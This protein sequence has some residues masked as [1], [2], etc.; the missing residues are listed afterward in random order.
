MNLWNRLAASLLSGF[1][2]F[3]VAL[4]VACGGLTLYSEHLNGDVQ[5][6]GP[7]AM[8]G[9]LALAGVLGAL[10]AVFSFIKIGE[11]RD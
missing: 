3:V 10:V 1:V 8:L 4:P 7:Q 5:T 6:A 11:P 9:G 2:S